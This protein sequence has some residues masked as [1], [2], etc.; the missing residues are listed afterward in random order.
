MTSEVSG[1][2]M[3]VCLVGV[4]SQVHEDCRA[5]LQELVPASKCELIASIPQPEPPDADV[6]IWD[7][8]QDMFWQRLTP[9]TMKRSLFVVEPKLLERFR[10]RLGTAHVSILLKPVRPAALRPFLEHAVRQYN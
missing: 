3:K 2:L 4:E 7:F 1:D 5:V 10:E 8:R 6:Y 9:E